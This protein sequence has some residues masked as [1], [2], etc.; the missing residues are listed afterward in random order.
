MEIDVLDAL[1]EDTSES[2]FK[3]EENFDLITHLVT[4]K[5]FRKALQKITDVTTI[6]DVDYFSLNEQKLQTWLDEKFD[7]LAKVIALDEKECPTEIKTAIKLKTAAILY[8][9]IPSP[10]IGYSYLVPKLGFKNAEALVSILFPPKPAAQKVFKGTKAEMEQAD[11]FI[12]K[13]PAR[14]FSKSV[15]VKKPPVNTSMPKKNQAEAPAAGKGQGIMKF[16]K[17][18]TE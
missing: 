6:S 15:G 12:N 2:S 16:F 13:P 11:G 5:T 17:K 14:T 7:R 1:D 8:N 3:R 9:E 10:I 4:S 18:K